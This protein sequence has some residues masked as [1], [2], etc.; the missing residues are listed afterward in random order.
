MIE[1]PVSGATDADRALYPPVRTLDP[2]CPV[3]RGDDMRALDAALCAGGRG[4][5]GHDGCSCACACPECM[6][7]LQQRHLKL[8]CISS[9]PVLI[10]I[11]LGI[12][13]LFG[14]ED[15]A[16]SGSEGHRESVGEVEA[17]AAGH[18]V[19]ELR[20]EVPGRADGDLAGE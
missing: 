18:G 4:L 13:G 16:P 8:G 9:G 10:A 6:G 3:C 19:A 1:D 5:C 7:S 11:A 17:G 2:R 12:Y 14:G 15:G 20:P